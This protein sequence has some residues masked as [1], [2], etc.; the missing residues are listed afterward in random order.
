MYQIE[1][2]ECGIKYVT[3][4]FA[5]KEDAL[6]YAEMNLNKYKLIRLEE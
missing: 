1:F 5:T 6:L 2:Y 3:E 4:Y